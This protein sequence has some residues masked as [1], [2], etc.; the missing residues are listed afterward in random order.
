[1][2]PSILVVE[3]DT[4]VRFLLRV[5]LER[6]GCGVT[7]AS[8]GNEALAHLATRR[9]DVIITD[10]M[11]PELSGYELLELIGK[12]ARRANVIVL[13]AVPRPDARVQTHPAVHAVIRKPFDITT[14][15]ANVRAITERRLLLVEDDEPAQYLVRRATESAGFSVTTVADG[16][17][18]LRQLAEKQFDAVVVDLNLPTI[19]GYDV[20]DHLASRE[21]RPSIVVLSVIDKPQIRTAVDAILHKPEGFDQV[22]PALLRVS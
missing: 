7:E 14:L 21:V 16:A 10:L 18:A 19:S 4:P 17:E 11:M 22:V 3:N 5:L 13:T 9:F 8:N 6:E 2:I 20:I 1:M 12:P 15:I